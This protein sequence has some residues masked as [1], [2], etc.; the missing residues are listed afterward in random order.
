MKKSLQ[1]TT[2]RRGAALLV[3][4][5][6][7]ALF[8][9]LGMLY[10]QRMEI[11]LVKADRTQNDARAHAI[12]AAGVN[13]ALGDI[14]RAAAAKQLVQVL[15]KPMT[16]AV[17]VYRP[18]WNGKELAVKEAKGRKSE[19]VVT[20]SDESAKVNLNHAPASVLQRILNVDGA[21]ARAITAALPRAG[22]A[23][24]RWMAGVDELLTRHLLTPE[25]YT[26]ADKHLLTVYTVADQ[27]HPA[28][29]LNVNTASPEVLAAILDAPIEAGPSI[30]A[31]RPFTSLAALAAAAGKDPATFNI[32]PDPNAAGELPLALT[33]ESRCFRIVSE[34]VSA[35]VDEKDKREHEAARV[36]VETVV[37]LKPEGGFDTVYWNETH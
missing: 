13:A 35:K 16:V 31:Q 14:A 7:L 21:T 29:F 6:L 36:R 18:E 2:T 30:A 32:K 25:Q 24:K 28:R 26:A 19:A 5:S 11:E 33:L 9:M 20:I 10:A 15:D 23:D 17:P 8:V 37:I 22:E 3:A 1:P 4:L 12:A 34:S 27:A